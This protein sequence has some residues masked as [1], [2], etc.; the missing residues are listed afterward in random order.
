MQSRSSCRFDGKRITTQLVDQAHQ[1]GASDLDIH[2]TV[3]IA[4]DF[5]MYNR[6]VD[7]L[8]T[9]RPHNDAMDMVMAKHMAEAGDCRPSE[10]ASTGM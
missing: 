5:C 9:A 1:H 8:Q 3:L 4:A 10:T 2:N 7:G 6:Y